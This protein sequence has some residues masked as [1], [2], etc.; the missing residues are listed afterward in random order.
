MGSWDNG[1][2]VLWDKLWVHGTMGQWDN[3]INNRITG[4]RDSE[5]TG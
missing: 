3:G 1:T 4:Q 2:V 5:T